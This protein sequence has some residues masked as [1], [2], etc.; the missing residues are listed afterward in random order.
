MTRRRTE[1]GYT[2][3]EVMMAVAIMT[4]GSVGILKLHQ[5]TTNGNRLARETSTAVDLNRRMIERVHRDALRWNASGLATST[6]LLS[7]APLTTASPVG[8]WVVPSMTIGSNAFDYQGNDTSTAADMYYCSNIRVSWIIGM[9][10]ARVDT[11]IWWRRG[12]ANPTPSA[13]TCATVPTD[14]Q[15]SSVHAVNASTVVRW[16]RLN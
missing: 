12:D 3:I 11:R 8:A 9:D 5:A 16:Q 15:L 6:E 7:N 14:A 4:V 1:E 10:A 2:L 13:W